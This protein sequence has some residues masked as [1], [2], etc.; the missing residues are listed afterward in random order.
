MKKSEIKSGDILE[1][2]GTRSQDLGLVVNTE[3]GLVVQ[4]DNRWTTLDSWDN[5]LDSIDN[6]E[7]FDIISIRR[8]V[9]EEQ[10][11]RAFIKNAPIVFERY[12]LKGVRKEF[13]KRDRGLRL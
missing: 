9:S 11:L 2:K 7:P 13:S 12:S 5:D 1:L 3:K 10:I 4:F 8:V 6:F